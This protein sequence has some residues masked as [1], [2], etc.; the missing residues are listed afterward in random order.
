MVYFVPN[1]DVRRSLSMTTV[2]VNV[3]AVASWGAL[4]CSFLIVLT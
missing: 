4:I 1:V 2:H 3:K